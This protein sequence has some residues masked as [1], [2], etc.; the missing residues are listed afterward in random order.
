[1]RGHRP[2]FK[3]D[4]GFSKNDSFMVILKLSISLLFQMDMCGNLGIGTDFAFI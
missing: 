4:M 3:L 1:M 2:N